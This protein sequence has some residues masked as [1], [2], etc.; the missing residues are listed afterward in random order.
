[1]NRPKKKKKRNTGKDQWNRV[2]SSEIDPH[3]Y[4]Q[5]MPDKRAKAIQ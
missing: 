5:L 1:M 2:E 4:S 3:R